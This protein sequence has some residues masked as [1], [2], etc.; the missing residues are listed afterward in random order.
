MLKTLLTS[1]WTP[2]L[3]PSMGAIV[4]ESAD[5][6]IPKGA[7]RKTLFV[8]ESEVDQHMGQDRSLTAR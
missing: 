3:T 5:R 7:P 4:M 6:W 2:T 1:G 8:E